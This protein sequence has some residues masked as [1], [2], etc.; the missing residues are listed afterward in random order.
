MRSSIVS[1]L[2]FLFAMSLAAKVRTVTSVG[3]V[4]KPRSYSG[5]CPVTLKFIGTIR[6]SR[7]P[8]LVDYVWERSDG[9]RGR[10]Q[11]VRIDSA[12]RSVSETWRLGSRRQRMQVWERLHVLAPTGISSP[13]A[14]VNVNCR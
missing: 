5:P 13:A 9:G 12:G 6:V 10:R 2:V 11:R 8:V 4:A 7:F 1:V 14:R 3:I